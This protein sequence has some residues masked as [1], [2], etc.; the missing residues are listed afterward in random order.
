MGTRRT[1]VLQLV[2]DGRSREQIAK[3]MFISVETVKSH[4]K[5]I[6]FQLRANTTT[7]AVAIAYREGI[8]Q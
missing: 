8:I 2:A 1:Q 7:H 6:R 4:L 3:E 5:E